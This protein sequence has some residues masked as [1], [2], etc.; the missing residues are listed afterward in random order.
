[1]L[2]DAAVMARRL[3]AAEHAAQ[4]TAA[5]AGALRAAL[6]DAEGI[7]AD[8]HAQLR[9]WAAHRDAAQTAAR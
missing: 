6:L 5:E 9:T 2:P 8:L 1:M 7:N 3:E 4:D